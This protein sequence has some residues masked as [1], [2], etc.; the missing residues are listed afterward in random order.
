[1]LAT[2]PIPGSPSIK[3]GSFNVGF[4]LMSIE[5]TMIVH[6]GGYLEEHCDIRNAV[7]TLQLSIRLLSLIE[8]LER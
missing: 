3:I 2:K 5:Q 4:S 1:M 8:H 7:A 6:F